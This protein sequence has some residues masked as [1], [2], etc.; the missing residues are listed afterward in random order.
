LSVTIRQALEQKY[1]KNENIRLEK[2][3]KQQSF[4]LGEI[5]K[6]Y[7]GITKVKRAS[8]GAIIIDDNE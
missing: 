2:I 6:K 7:P 3:V 4:S 1:L 5:E 8:G